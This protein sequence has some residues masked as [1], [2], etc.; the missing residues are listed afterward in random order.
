TH[1]RSI[2]YP[3]LI[4]AL[5]TSALGTACRSEPQQQ[6][7][8]YPPQQQYPPQQYPAQQYPAQP[9]PAAYSQP[10]AQPPPGGVPCGSDADPQCPFGR[11]IAGKCGG[12]NTVEHCKPGAACMQ[13]PVGMT[14][15]PGGM[16]G[17]PPAQ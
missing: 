3:L 11:C 17:V 7:A 2:P 5:L 1:T 12:C 16:P 15:V 10:G 9:Y 14:C 13:T 8:H 4:V 6:E